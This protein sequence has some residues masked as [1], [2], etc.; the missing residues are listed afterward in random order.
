M[1]RVDKCSFCGS[2][3]RPGT[4]LT[5]V[6]NDGT[7]LH[8]CSSKCFKNYKLGR[9]AKRTPWSKYFLGRKGRGSAT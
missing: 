7:L 1:V 9:D 6:K 5:L 8:F 3:V 2:E 4:G